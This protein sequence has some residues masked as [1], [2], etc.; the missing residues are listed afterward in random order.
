VLTTTVVVEDVDL[1]R[2]MDLGLHFRLGETSLTCDSVTA[3]LLG[4]LYSGISIEGSDAVRM[5]SGH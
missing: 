2:D 3:T 1:D 5:V 4:E